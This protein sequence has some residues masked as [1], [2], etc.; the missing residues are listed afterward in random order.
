M[1]K[2]P[3]GHRKRAS[4]HHPR[5]SRSNGMSVLV[6]SGSKGPS[7]CVRFAPESDIK[8]DIWNVR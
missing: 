3:L 1:E 5:K 7:L 6:K 4:T 8:C 2:E